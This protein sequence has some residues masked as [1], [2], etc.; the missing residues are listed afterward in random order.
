MSNKEKIDYLILDLRELE[1]L[2]ASMRDAEVYPVSFFSKTFDLTHKILTDLH[3]LENDQ[4]EVLRKQMEEH[5]SLIKDIQISKAQ[6]QPIL[7]AE[8]QNEYE[9]A[10]DEVEVETEPEAEEVIESKQEIIPP[11]PVLGSKQ[12]VSLY[13][14]IEKKNLSDFRKAL[15]LNDRFYFRRELFGGD[16]AKMS[17]VISDL[18]DIQ[19]YEESI[20]YLNEKLNWNIEDATVTE[21][22]KLLEKRF[23]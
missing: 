22:V 12:S 19:T 7:P 23:M 21:F 10:M 3:K 4:I 15:N 14:M 17:K 6:E 5:H 2:V 1:Q 8:P 16:E 18:N 13:D 11:S 20:S 9:L